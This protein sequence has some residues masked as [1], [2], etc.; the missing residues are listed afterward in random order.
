MV[1]RALL[2]ALRSKGVHD[3]I[4]A[5]SSRLDLR[6]QADVRSFFQAEKPDRVI[7]AAAKVG[8]IAANNAYPA[9]FLYDNLM[10]TANVIEAAFVTGV[11]RLLQLGS[12]CIYPRDAVQPINEDALLTGALEP[13]NQPYALAKIAGIELCQSYNRQYGTD[14][15]SVMPTNL[16]G[17]HDNFHPQNAHVL[18]ALMARFH[19]AAASHVET[20]TIWG[21]GNPLRE[22]LHVD[23]MAAACLF[24]LGLPQDAYVQATVS[25]SHLNVGSGQEVSIAALASLVADITGYQGEV[26]FDPAQPDGTPRKLLD[27]TRLSRLGWMAEIPLRDGIV[28]TYDW[29]QRQLISG[30]IRLK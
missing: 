7:L 30:D 5:D 4:T 2:R 22:F 21:T 12:S 3:I 29:Y 17:P 8:G 26:T 18:P 10:I 19:L 15:R 13:T 14:Y 11:E 20:V 6:N 16:Y 25:Q 23:D 27:V 9:A 28:S 1:G 24:V